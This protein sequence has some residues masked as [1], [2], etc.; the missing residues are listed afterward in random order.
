ME[1]VNLVMNPVFIKYREFLDCLW[2]Y[3]LLKENLSP[4]V[5]YRI[6]S[7]VHVWY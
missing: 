7:D 4:G 3:G 6:D 1:S 2:T 5:S